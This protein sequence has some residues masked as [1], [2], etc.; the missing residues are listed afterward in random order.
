MRR[1][2][3]QAIM[4]RIATRAAA[5]AIAVLLAAT[6]SAKEDLHWSGAGWYGVGDDMFG[7]WIMTAPLPD[8]ASCKAG[9]PADNEDAV[10]ACEY[11]T[12]KPGW[13]E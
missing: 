2:T 3:G 13:D 9:Q 6:A 10:Y 12:E 11:L 4:G 5:I 1:F 8:E 7:Q